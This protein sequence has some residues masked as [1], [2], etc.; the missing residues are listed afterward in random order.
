MNILVQVMNIS[1]LS[2]SISAIRTFPLDA[3]ILMSLSYPRPLNANP[4]IYS[5]IYYSSSMIT[6]IMI[7]TYCRLFFKFILFIHLL[8]PLLIDLQRPLYRSEIGMAHMYFK[9][10]LNRK[11]ISPLDHWPSALCVRQQWISL[12]PSCTLVLRFLSEK[13]SK[14]IT[15]CF[16]S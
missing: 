9:I 2:L 12:S 15:K 16:H 11:L 10:V 7:T 13:I 3:Y 4:S 6:I 14:R 1:H 8:I 5:F